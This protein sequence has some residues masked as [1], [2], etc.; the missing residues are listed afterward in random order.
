MCRQK[1]RSSLVISVISAFVFGLILTVFGTSQ[2]A[3]LLK[4][5]T[6]DQ[7]QIAIK[8]RQVQVVI[9]TASPGPKWIRNSSI[10]A[11]A[12]SRPFTPFRFRSRP[13]SP[14]SVSG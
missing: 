4:P 6:G 5:K 1:K 7:A 10:P 8:S 9:I 3:G 2:A 12:M 11:T 13:A 14:N